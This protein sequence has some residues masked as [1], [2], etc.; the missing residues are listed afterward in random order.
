MPG[1]AVGFN[2][3]YVLEGLDASKGTSF[4]NNELYSYYKSIK[5]IEVAKATQTLSHYL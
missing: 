1:C 4:E 2:E 5:I 3:I